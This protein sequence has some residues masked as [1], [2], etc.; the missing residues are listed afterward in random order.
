MQDEH[1]I[2]VTDQPKQLAGRRLLQGNSDGA[3]SPSSAEATRTAFSARELYHA[4]LDM[5]P[6]IEMCPL[7]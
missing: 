5:V 3:S 4:D 7:A 6:N 2:T 1:S